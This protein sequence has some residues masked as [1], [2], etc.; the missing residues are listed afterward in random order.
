MMGGGLKEDAEA[1]LR[2]RG[3]DPEMMLLKMINTPNYRDGMTHVM[4][5][6]TF[7]AKGGVRIFDLDVKRTVNNDSTY[8]RIAM[9]RD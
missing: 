9:L 4:G 1:F 3:M 6:Y 8:V 7:K 2:E 5:P